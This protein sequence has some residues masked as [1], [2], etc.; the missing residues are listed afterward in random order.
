MG[1]IEEL[2]DSAALLVP[3]GDIEEAARQLIALADNPDQRRRLREAGLRQS[4]SWP[5]EDDVVTDLVAV[6]N[7]VTRDR[8]YKGFWNE[9]GGFTVR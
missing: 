2:V 5:D 3:P 9:S 8:R 1:G 6:Y 7:D 4:A